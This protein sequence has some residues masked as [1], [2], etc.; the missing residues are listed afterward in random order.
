VKTTGT[1][2]DLAARVVESLVALDAFT[3]ALEVQLATDGLAVAHEQLVE[4]LSTVP[5]ED[6]TELC[7]LAILRLS[8]GGRTL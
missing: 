7:S 8:G 1:T 3:A 2:E 6:V 5:P 4:R